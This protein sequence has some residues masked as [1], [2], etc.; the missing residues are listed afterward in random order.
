MEFLS[1]KELHEKREDLLEE[2][3]APIRLRFGR[4]EPSGARTTGVDF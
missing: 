2:G 4:S 1:P 3:Y